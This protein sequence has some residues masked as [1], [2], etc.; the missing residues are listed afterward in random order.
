MI[1]SSKCA[2]SVDFSCSFVNPFS[3]LYSMNLKLSFHVLFFYSSLISSIYFNSSLSYNSLSIFILSIELV[4]LILGSVWSNFYVLGDFQD[5][6]DNLSES[7]GSRVCILIKCQIKNQ[8]IN[9]KRKRKKSLTIYT[10]SELLKSTR[11]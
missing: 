10:I 7:S 2:F 1:I 6:V 8:M 4:H 3:Y 11:T 5:L 9:L